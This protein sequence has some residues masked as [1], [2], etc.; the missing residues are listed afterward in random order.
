MVE[1]FEGSKSEA[2]LLEILERYPD[3]VVREQMPETISIIEYANNIKEVT[4]SLALNRET[5]DVNPVISH[6]IPD[7]A[8]YVYIEFTPAGVV[9]RGAMDVNLHEIMELARAGLQIMQVYKQ[10][11]P[12]VRSKIFSTRVYEY[13]VHVGPAQDPMMECIERTLAAIEQE[14][15]E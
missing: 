1:D 11:P 8:D 14:L 15:G 7:T 3:L 9:T 5:N 10:I 2:D 13:A 4:V 12:E 6:R